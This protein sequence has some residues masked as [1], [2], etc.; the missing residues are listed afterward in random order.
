MNRRDLL[1]V[2]A[3]VAAAGKALAQTPGWQPKLFDAH[4]NDTVVALAE[5][6]IPATDTAGAKAAQVNRYIDLLLSDG[7]AE[8]RNHFLEG[9]ALLDSHAI[10]SHGQPFVRCAVRQQT[11]ML[12]A[13]DENRDPGAAPGRR[14]FG[15]MKQLTSRIYYSTEAGFRELNKGGRASSTFGCRH[16]EHKA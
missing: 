7:P 15:M 12:K 2:T 5:L 3:T 9:L 13:F 4:Q 1:K 11:A 6:I 14:F 8:E 16:P 10:R